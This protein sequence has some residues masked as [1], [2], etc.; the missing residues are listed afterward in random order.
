MTKHEIPRPTCAFCDRRP[1]YVL[2]VSDPAPADVAVI[3]DSVPLPI[4]MDHFNDL[5]AS[6]RRDAGGDRR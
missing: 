3:S 1:E 4:C 5:R 6:A 2:S